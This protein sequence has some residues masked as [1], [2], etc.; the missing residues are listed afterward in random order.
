M[1]AR[2]TKSLVETCMEKSIYLPP[3]PTHSKY[4]A[5]FIR[6][7][8]GDKLALRCVSP[9][10]AS[11]TLHSKYTDTRHVVLYSHGN[12]TDVGECQDMCELLATMLN[13]HV[14][15]YDYPNYGASS[16]T[17]TRMSEV[18]LNASIE[19]VYTRCREIGVPPAKIILM[20]QSLGSVPTLNLA[21]R[22]ST[23]YCAVILVSPLASA[24]RAVMSDTFVSASPTFVSS[25]LDS[26][27][28]DNLK[29]VEGARAPV[30]I[31]H[32]FDDEVIDISCAQLL[33][34]RI[35]ARF[36]HAPLYIEAGH[37]D[38]YSEDT[39]ASVSEY[40][41]DFV[42]SASEAHG[43]LSSDASPD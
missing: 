8:S 29:A 34:S 38:V 35:P 42:R 4:T 22:P 3:T 36:Q 40:L 1:G 26:L 9:A 5:H 18:T 30:A 19:S 41:Q 10:E 21:A 23:K 43:K 16:K 28:F 17:R 33:H 32:G 14:V 37:N 6:T 15:V 12:A 11:M 20:G 7:V 27:L 31:V 2:M 39:L 24:F 13:A 25:R